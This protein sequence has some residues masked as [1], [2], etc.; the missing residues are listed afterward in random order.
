V[1]SHSLT[2]GSP[3]TPHTSPKGVQ[4]YLYAATAFWGVSIGLISATLPFRFEQ[5]GLPV[6]E[7]GVAL[8]VYAAAMIPTESLWGALAFRLGRPRIL[9]AIGAVV[10]GA[11]LLLG[12]ARS[13]PLILLAE[14]LL[15]AFGVYLAPVLRWVSFTHGGPG[16]EGTGTGRW[17]SAFGLGIAVGLALGPVGFVTVGFLDVAIESVAVF[18]VAVAAAALLPWSRVSLPSKEPGR[19]F[20]VRDVATRPFLIA[21]VLVVITF[22]AM[23][24]TSNFL[25]YYST[26]LFGG[27]ASDAGF[28]LGAARLVSLATAFLL[29]TLVD[30]WGPAR[31]IPAGFGL[32]LAGGLATWGAHSYDEMVAATLLFS[33]GVGWLSASL[34]PLALNAMPRDHQGTAI[35]VFGSMEDAGLL[36]GPL[37]FGAAWATYGPRSLFPLVT[38]LAAAGVVVSLLVAY[39]SLWTLRSQTGRGTLARELH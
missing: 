27:T 1:L 38:A 5:L 24:F 2:A 7:Y 39:G 15:G 34:L 28:V 17:S 29:G 36:I 9:I 12:Y 31:S 20:V 26:V 3:A 6:L 8:S 13:F 11:T 35:G 23:T 25:Q 32:L 16:S 19:R 4:R 10:C 30:R 14:V 33:A 37:L 22:T 21:V 18:A